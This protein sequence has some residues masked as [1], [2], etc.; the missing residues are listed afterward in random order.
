MKSE[1]V[2]IGGGINGCAL[3]YELSRQDVSV[4]LVEKKYLTYGATG[5]C[6]A[7]IRQQWSTRENVE[8]SMNSVKIFKKLQHEYQW[9]I[10]LRQGGYL[11]VI[12]DEKEL[13]QMKKNIQMQQSLGL[14]V[15]LIEKDNISQIVPSLNPRGMDAIGAT[16]CPSDG[17][18]DPFKTTYAYAQ[19][20]RAHGA[21]L[22]TQTEVT[23]IR[24]LEGEI[25]EVKTTRGTI[26][27]GIV[28]NAAGAWSQRIAKMLD[29]SVPNVPFRK[30]ILVTER[31]QPLFDAMVIS[32]RD[33]IYFSQMEGGQIVGG[34]PIPDEQP[35]YIRNSTF[36][37]LQHMSR[38]LTRYMPCLKHLN[39]LRQW[40]GFYDV[41]P[42]SLPI[43]GETPGLKRF[44]QCHGFSGHGF[45]VAPM[46][47]RLL[48]KLII[49]EKSCPILNRL[50]LHRFRDKSW[51][52][53][54]KSVVG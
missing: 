29:V 13:D 16:F 36:T 24:A 25:Q 30:E 7:G 6:G 9:D 2:I 32:F 54:E 35:G 48:S 1:V 4:I 22:Y 46:I 53:H 10:G 41:T 19:A 40:M 47:A 5:R 3:A 38:T 45:M 18:A 42:D 39:V 17:H 27:T 21:K 49:E 20:A 28:I 33:G 43:L 37:F 23:D 14:D 50:G 11:I 44:I 34:I 12:H 26:K 31:L 52:I 15:S 51:T 8:L